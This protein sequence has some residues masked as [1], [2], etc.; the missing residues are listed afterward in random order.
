M[1][2]IHLHLCSMTVFRDVLSLKV[3]KPVL[4]FYRALEHGKS[5][6]YELVQLYASVYRELAATSFDS[7]S[8]YLSH[9]MKHDE[10]PYPEA[11]AAS[12]GNKLRGA[13]LRDINIIDGLLLECSQMKSALLQTISPHLRDSIADLPEIDGGDAIGLEDLESSYR[14]NGT[15]V[16]SQG[17]AFLWDG[18]GV[19]LVGNP[20]MLRQEDMIGYHWQRQEVIKNSRALI[21]GK[22]AS[23]VLLHGDSGTGKSATIKSLIHIP[24]FY[25]LRII[26]IAREGMVGLRSLIQKLAGKSQKFILFIDD[27]SFSAGEEGYGALKSILEGGMGMRPDNVVVYATSNRRHMVRESF[28]ERQGDDIHVSETIQEKSSLSD[29][30]GIRIPYMALHKAEFLKTVDSIAKRRGINMDTAELHD[31]A[32]K[33][34]I[35]HGGR[36]PRVARQFIDYLAADTP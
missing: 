21:E 17:R 8:Q 10:G 29:R 23:N 12:G 2:N 16:F 13:A 27:L 24:E 1:N 4:G 7:L 31:R 15:G 35:G 33:W 34:E 14:R 11:V 36:T 25:N 19:S 5:T 26:E 20:D 6:D 30:F 9:H 18:S 32:N 3:M 28:S 22:G